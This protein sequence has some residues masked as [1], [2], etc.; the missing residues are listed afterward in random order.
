MQ[1]N[2]LQNVTRLYVPESRDYHA[3]AERL[4]FITGGCTYSRNFGLWRDA[5]T[6]LVSESIIVLTLW[7]DNSA[8]SKV[9]DAIALE[10]QSLLQAG[11]LSVALE[12]SGC[13]ELYTL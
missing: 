11:E 4:A 6:T 8:R 13:M 1:V 7:Y 12:K 9:R 5:E 3:I 2:T 10:I